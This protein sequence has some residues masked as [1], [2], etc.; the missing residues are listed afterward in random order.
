[1]NWPFGLMNFGAWKVI[2]NGKYDAVVLQSWT[3]MVWWVAFLACLWFKTDVFFMTDSNILS[4]SSKTV[5]KKNIKHIFLGNLLFKY[6]A[7]FFT[8]GK[9]NEMFYEN[10]GVPAQKMIHM[11]FSWGYEKMLEKA[12]KMLPE[13]S[14]IRELLGLA[15]DDFVV[16]YVGRLS[17]EKMPLILLEAYQKIS[18]PNKKLWIVGDGP[19]RK[20]FT[21]VIKQYDIKGVTI[22]GF[23]PHERTAEFYA[24]SDV[25]VL[26]SKAETWGIVVNEAMCFG[27]PV[28]ASDKVGSVLDLLQDGYN[29]F[30]FPVGNVEELSL[31]IKK[32]MDFSEEQRR[33]FSQRSIDIIKKWVSSIKPDEQI[34]TL[35]KTVKK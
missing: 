17:E 24:A 12:E 4:E 35:L 31:S 28:I 27:L 29:G 14:R 21:D 18:A 30:V 22:F 26:P 9:A 1:M 33:L 11:P 15:K 10:Y 19:M 5:W 34:I 3:N 23:V 7:G 8:S 13:R 20:Q 6:S 32:I 25:L 16:L 2:K